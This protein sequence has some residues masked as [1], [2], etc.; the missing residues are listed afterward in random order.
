MTGD[1]ESDYADESSF[2]EDSE[3]IN[4]V[5]TCEESDQKENGKI[6]NE[7]MTTANKSFTLPSHSHKHGMSYLCE[8][9]NHKNSAKLL[10]SASPISTGRGITCIPHQ[11]P[12]TLASKDVE[13]ITTRSSTA[14]SYTVVIDRSEQQY[15][16]DTP[17]LLVS[18]N[19]SWHVE[20]HHTFSYAVYI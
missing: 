1:N 8:I 10:L 14:S 12:P 17:A 5:I 16:E 15:N 2:E 7:E 13:T 9:C 20:Q 18:I 3:S 6:F 11:P 4:S 19:A